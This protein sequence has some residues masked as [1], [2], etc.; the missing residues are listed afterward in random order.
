VPE[1]QRGLAFRAETHRSAERNSRVR[2]ELSGGEAHFGQNRKIAVEGVADAQ[3]RV[4]LAES[5]QHAGRSTQAFRRALILL[6]LLLS[7]NS[8]FMY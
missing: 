7:S 5:G 3:M 4:I 2:V 1:D 6:I 8:C